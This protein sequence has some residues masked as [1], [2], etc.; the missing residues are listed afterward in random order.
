MNE[1]A[2]IQHE[3]VALDVDLI[4]RT[5]CRGATDEELRLFYVALTRART[6]LTVT[7]PRSRSSFQGN[8]DQPPPEL[9]RFL[10]A[11]IKRR[12]DV[13]NS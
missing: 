2:R 9:T 3:P 4:K 10:P 8:W 12:F 5:I 11:K 13:S 1:V 7:W 6:W